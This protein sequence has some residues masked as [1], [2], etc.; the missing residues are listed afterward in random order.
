MLSAFIR[1]NTNGSSPCHLCGHALVEPVAEFAALRRVTSDCKP[2]AAGGWLGVCRAC[3]GVQKRMDAA[4]RAEIERVYREYSIYHQSGGTEQ[5]AFS[6]ETGQGKARSERIVER[7]VQS[8]LAADR[9]RLLDVGCGNGA[10]LRAGSQQLAGWSLVGTEINDK[11]QATVEAIPG[12]ERMHVGG[13]GEVPGQF[14]LVTLVHVLEHI[15]SP[16]AFLESLRPK[17]T[18]GGRLLVEVPHYEANPF[19][20]LIVDHS[21]HFSASVLRG[22]AER[23]G[24]Q[25]AL[26]AT[27]WV[28]KEL[29]LVAHPAVAALSARGEEGGVFGKV[30]DELRERIAWLAQVAG[31]ARALASRG[32]FGLFG[33]SI[34]AVW[35]FGE[36]DGRVD[37]FVDEDPTRVGRTCFGRPVL[38]PQQAP[39]GSRALMALPP[40]I[41]ERVRARLAPQCP[42]L[43]FHVP[44]PIR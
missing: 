39:A 30:R 8:G 12:V 20:L 2:W 22:V 34:A 14:D 27:D 25:P 35:L 23:A 4:W 33:T 9:G 17:L 38:A 29:T 11:Y 16:A 1:M 36:L 44:P 32:S 19:D 42:N 10:L 28:A 40:V 15:E 7:V 43:E 18:P 41:A 5:S 13:A 37:F 21:T 6:A 24:Y 3:G 31:Q 26:L